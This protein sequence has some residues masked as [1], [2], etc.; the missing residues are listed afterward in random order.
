MTVPDDFGDDIWTAHEGWLSSV[1]IQIV[2]WSLN[3]DERIELR[4]AIGRIIKANLSL[5]DHEG[6]I[7]IEV[8]QQDVEDFTSFSAPVYQSM[9]SFSCLAPS[10]ISI[11]DPLIVRTVNPTILES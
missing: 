4:K 8:S 6:M 1:Q 9:A 10:H 7:Q 3:A 2:G 11:A 5:F